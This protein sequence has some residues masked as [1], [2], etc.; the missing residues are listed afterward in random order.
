MYVI[1]AHLEPQK[2]HY[3]EADFQ[4]LL[5]LKIFLLTSF[6]QQKNKANNNGTASVNSNYKSSYV[7]SNFMVVCIM[8]IRRVCM[9][10]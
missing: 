3:K 6:I 7:A 10:S 1:L 9:K 4:H 5:L 2:S 8:L